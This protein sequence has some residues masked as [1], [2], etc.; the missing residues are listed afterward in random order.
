MSTDIIKHKRIKG[1]CIILSAIACVLG[2][3]AYL[4]SIERAAESAPQAENSPSRTASDTSNVYTLA[5]V[6]QH[7]VPESCWIAA[8][9]V[10][11]DITPYIEANR[12]PGGQQSLTEGC[13]ADVTQSFDRIHSTQA[14]DMLEDYSIGILLDD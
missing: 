5:D 8:Y 2:L 1:I 10:V 4:I 11:Y 7:D 12:H 3:N 14:R 13:G 9:G 6:A